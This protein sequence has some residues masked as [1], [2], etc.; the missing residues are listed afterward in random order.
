MVMIGPD[1]YE[2]FGRPYN[3]RIAKELGGIAIHSCGS[4][5]HNFKSAIHTRSVRMIDLAMTKLCDPGPNSP[6]DVISAFSGSG[7]PLQ[8]RLGYDD[9]D[10]IKGLMEADIKTVLLFP[11][12]DDPAERQRRYDDIKG[13]WELMKG[14]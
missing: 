12:H 10:A 6:S 7:V 4:W 8:A 14:H 11:W 13:M 9:K 2:E 1:F 5:K 3:E